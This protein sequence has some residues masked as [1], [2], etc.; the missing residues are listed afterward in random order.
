[1]NCDEEINLKKHL[2]ACLSLMLVFTACGGVRDTDAEF[3]TGSVAVVQDVT[4]KPVTPQAAPAMIEQAGE[5]D[6][7]AVTPP[8]SAPVSDMT[9]EG[10]LESYLSAQSALFGVLVPGMKENPETAMDAIYLNSAPMR[11]L[12]NAAAMWERGDT[13][14]G[15]TRTATYTAGSTIQN[16]KLV[17]IEETATARYEA[18]KGRLTNDVTRDGKLASCT[19]CVKTEYGWIA[20]YYEPE[21]SARSRDSYRV[22]IAI[23]GGDGIIGIEPGAKQPKALNGKEAFELPLELRDRFVLDGTRIKVHS[24]EGADTEFDIVSAPA[25]DTATPSTTTHI[26]GDGSPEL[27]YLTQYDGYA[28]LLH[29][30]IVGAVYRTPLQ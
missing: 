2:L 5:S 22:L 30:W 12:E 24:A 28:E 1:M 20:Q 19:E 27:I 3:P 29:G 8:V 23:R 17:T 25:L 7:V 15:D 18:D 26:P 6:Y 9:A 21:D 13:G 14:Q 4:A 16:G 11:G 10:F